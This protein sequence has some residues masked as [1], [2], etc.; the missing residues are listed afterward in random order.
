M[1]WLITVGIISLLVGAVALFSSEKL[2]KSAELLNKPIYHLDNFLSSIRIPV[3]AIL[4]ITGGWLVSVAF[5][6]PES[7]Y[8]HLI[9]VIAIFIGMLYIFL[10]EWLKIMAKM[11]DQTLFSTDE[12]VTGPRKI[13]G[14]VCL[15]VAL[16]IFYAVFLILK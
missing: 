14:I 12:L 2:R 13:I 3:G 5:S 10:P 6:Y 1:E 16:Y 9:G 7:W 11:A 15:I 4:I 8:F